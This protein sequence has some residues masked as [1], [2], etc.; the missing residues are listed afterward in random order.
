MEINL[1]KTALYHELKKSKTTAWKL[2]ESAKEDSELF[3]E[4]LF[5]QMFPENSKI[6]E[7]LD[8]MQLW[9][10][11]EEVYKNA[12]MFGTCHAHNVVKTII[13]ENT[14]IRP[15]GMA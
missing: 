2:E 4:R 13:E 7:A 15:C 1:Y 3:K 8:K 5:S 6:H 14:S 12:F 11:L 9:E 10:L